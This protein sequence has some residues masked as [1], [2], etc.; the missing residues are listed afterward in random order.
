MAGWQVPLAAGDVDV[1]ETEAGQIVGLVGS[2]GRNITTHGFLSGEPEPNLLFY[3]VA[4]RIGAC[5]HVAFFP[6]IL[7]SAA[8]FRL[9]NTDTASSQLVC[10]S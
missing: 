8:P 2:D 4:F 6:S 5:L 10:G 3:L 9:R 7:S 1:A